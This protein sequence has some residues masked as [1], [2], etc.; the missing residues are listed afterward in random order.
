MSRKKK[1]E[2][3]I[4]LLLSAAIKPE[5]PT[6]TKKEVSITPEIPEEITDLLLSTDEMWEYI[7]KI[8]ENETPKDHIR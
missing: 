1:P 8:E 2:E 7:E 3:I 4:N 5:I 6:E